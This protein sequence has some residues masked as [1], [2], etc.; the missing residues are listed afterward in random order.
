[1]NRIGERNPYE[2]GIMKRNA[3]LTLKY[4]GKVS[5]KYIYIQ[6]R[7]ILR[8]EVSLKKNKY[9][10]YFHFSSILLYRDYPTFCFYGWLSN[11]FFIENMHIWEKNNDHH[12]LYEFKI[13]YIYKDFTDLQ[14]N[15]QYI[16]I[17]FLIQ[18]SYIN[19]SFWNLYIHNYKFIFE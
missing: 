11:I 16:Y 13:Y 15:I 5:I 1:M 3:R 10:G 7:Y 18:A 6:K 12:A 4:Q 17:V 14:L 19:P 8:I 9:L 2:L